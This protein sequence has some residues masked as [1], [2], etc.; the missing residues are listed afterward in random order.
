[1][2]YCKCVEN[3]LYY[4]E[5][6]N[7]LQIRKVWFSC[8]D[9]I[10][11][12][13]KRDIQTDICKNIIANIL[14]PIFPM[15]YCKYSFYFHF[16][17]WKIVSVLKINCI[18]L[19]VLTNFK[20]EKNWF[21][22]CDLIPLDYRKEYINLETNIIYCAHTYI[23]LSYKTT[24][25]LGYIK[26]LDRINSNF[27]ISLIKF[28]HTLFDPSTIINPRSIGWSPG[29]ISSIQRKVEFMW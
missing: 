18:M 24:H 21:S 19:K 5:S 6:L 15:A 16:S 29:K 4:V 20:S 28:A 14:L 17:Q 23:N 7:K 2:A 27:L 8:Y 10:P 26:H 25:N 22:C 9:F 3:Q 1:M 11:I 13:Y 12:V